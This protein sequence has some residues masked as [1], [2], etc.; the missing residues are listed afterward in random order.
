MESP[1]AMAQMS[2]GNFL[3][4]LRGAQWAPGSHG[5]GFD[6]LLTSSQLL[7]GCGSW[8]LLSRYALQRCKRS[9]KE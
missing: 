8:P 1:Q 4:W 9:K 5:T 6:P 7:R 3:E 2:T